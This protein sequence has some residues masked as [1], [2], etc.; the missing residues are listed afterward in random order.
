MDLHQ[1]EVVFV[2]RKKSQ[3]L[4]SSHQF[5]CGWEDNADAE[6]FWVTL[7]LNGIEVR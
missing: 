4:A 1:Y 7:N 2:F 6:V 3:C 5:T